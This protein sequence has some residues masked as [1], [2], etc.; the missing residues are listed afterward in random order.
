MGGGVGARGVGG[1]LFV[2]VRKRREKREG[3]GRGF[4]RGGRGGGTGEGVRLLR[5]KWILI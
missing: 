5:R 3:E 1:L 2:A 4:K